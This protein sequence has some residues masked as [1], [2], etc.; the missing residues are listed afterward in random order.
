MRALRVG[1]VGLGGIAQK[2]YLPLL[3]QAKEW[4]LIGAYTPNQEKNFRLCQQYR[5]HPFSSLHELAEQCDVAFIH[6]ATSSHYEI[7]KQLLNAG[8]HVYIDKPLAETYDQAEELVSL[9]EQKQQT[10]MVGFNRRFAPFYQKAKTHMPLTASVRFEKH[11]MNGIQNPSRFTLLDDYLHVLDTLLWLADGSLD[12]LG[13]QLSTTATDEL[14]YVGHHFRHEHQLLSA[15][16]HRDAGSGAEI[17]DLVT[18]GS[19]IR[20]RDMSRV[21]EERN[22]QTIISNA[23][24]WQT[25]LELRGFAPMVEHFLTNVANQTTPDI[26]GEQALMAQ[27]WMEKLIAQAQS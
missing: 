14:I 22:G 3:S 2:V 8:L 11:R 21:E 5:I 24:S 9:A 16:M 17:L 6:S 10:L 15:A 19:L 7:T 13:G 23:G 26:C 27:R 4:D 12:F 20:V 25:T 1:L 18:H